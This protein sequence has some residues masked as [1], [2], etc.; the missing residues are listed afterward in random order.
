[1]LK[2][3]NLNGFNS[4]ATKE[5]TFLSTNVDAVIRS[6][7]TFTSINLGNPRDDRDIFICVNIL[8]QGTL[9]TIS[10]ATIAGVSCTITNLLNNTFH[11]LSVIHCRVPIS[12]GSTGNVNINISG[13]VDACAITA[14][15]V[16]GYD[17]GSSK[18]SAAA[19]YT[20]DNSANIT[21]DI[22]NYNIGFVFCTY[23]QSGTSNRYYAVGV[24]HNNT[25][26]L[27]NITR[28]AANN[29][30]FTGAVEVADKVLKS[31]LGSANFI[32]YAVIWY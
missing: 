7:Y 6:S 1:M 19:S 23:N 15:S 22:S 11:N 18:G 5:Y 27:L 24:T 28:T 21:V 25:V 17:L 14:F 9:R 30:T 4:F 12:A 10:S 13:N 20:T 29:V 3:N 2:V 31:L 8:A 26:S 32:N 16:I